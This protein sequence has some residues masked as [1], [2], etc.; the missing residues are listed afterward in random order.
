VIGKGL[1]LCDAVEL[2]E[3]SDGASLLAGAA[4][5]VA[6]VR[7]MRDNVWTALS[8]A[9]ERPHQRSINTRRTIARLRTRN[10]IVASISLYRLKT[11]AWGV[12]EVG[13]E[14][15]WYVP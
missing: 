11:P 1:L 13:Q 3:V 15:T 2:N 7:S 6:D 8:L 12:D 5:A 4:D 9:I 10:S 14:T